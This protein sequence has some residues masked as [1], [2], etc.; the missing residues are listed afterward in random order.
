MTLERKNRR[1]VARRKMKKKNILAR[2]LVLLFL[3][4]MTI[5]TY[6]S[7]SERVNQADNLETHLRHIISTKDIS[8]VRGSARGRVLSSAG[9]QISDEG[10]GILGVYAET[11]CHTSVKQIY[12]TI[13]LDVWDEER[14]DWVTLDLYDYEW[15]ASDNPDKSLTDVSVSFELEGLPRGRTYSLRGTHIARNFDNVT[16]VMSSETSGIVLD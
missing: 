16:E 12:M 13:Y 14:Q 3:S 9:L 8:Q 11:L 15:K 7:S 4:A 1:E 10:Q 6:A 5:T 2:F